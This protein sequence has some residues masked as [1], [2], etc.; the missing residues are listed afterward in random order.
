MKVSKISPLKRLVTVTPETTLDLLN[1]YMVV[2]EGDMVYAV[3]GREMKKE[4]SDGSVDSERVRVEVGVEVER[5]SL[6]PLMR[7]LDLL[8]VIRYES[9]EIGLLGKYHSIHVG[10]GTELT[11]ESRRNFPRLESMASYY[12]SRPLKRI[13]VVMLDDEGMS[14]FSIG[15]DDTETLYRKRITSAGKHDPD[16]RLK[17]IHQLFSSGA[18]VLEEKLDENVEILVFGPSIYLDDFMKH[19]R[20]HRKDLLKRIRKAGYVSDSSSAGLP[21]ILRSGL[22]HEY[23]ESLKIVADAEAV[24]NL[25]ARLVSKPEAVAVGLREALAAVEMGAVD[26]LLISEDFLWEKLS[27][28]DVAQ[29]LQRAENHKTRVQVITSNSESSDKLKSLGGVAAMLR[30]SVDLSFLRSGEGSPNPTS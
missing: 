20:E 17:S 18:T 25:L 7:R 4:R 21:E 10:L 23:G 9:R 12:R 26:R 27:E 30:Y 15:P 13:A 2:E 5:K 19:L 22:L 14:I 24:E 29:L 3:V 1:L 11:L 8:G 28:P 16:E 6:N